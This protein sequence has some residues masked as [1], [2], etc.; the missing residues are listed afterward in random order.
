MGRRFGFKFK[1]IRMRTMVTILPCVLIAMAILVVMSYQSSKTIINEE[2]DKV[3]TNELEVSIAS[4]SIDLVA[5]R[6]VPIT[7]ARTVE[8]IGNELTEEEYVEL[9]T[10]FIKSNDGTLGTGV[11][12]EPNRYQPNRTYFGPYVYRDGDTIIFTSEY[13]DPSYDFHNEEWYLQGKSIQDGDAAVWSDPYFDDAGDEVLTF[14]STTA[15]FFDRHGNFMG[16]ATGDIELT[17]LLE[18]ISEITIGETGW[19]FMLGRDGTYIASRESEKIMNVNIKSDENESL[20]QL[21]EKM[22]AEGMGTSRF[23]NEDGWNRVYYKT[24]PETGWTMA[25]VIPEKELYAPLNEL[26]IK[27]LIITAMATGIVILVIFMFSRYFSAKVKSVTTLSQNMSEGDFTHRLD[28]DSVDEF[29]QMARNFNSMTSKLNDIFRHTLN[30]TESVAVSAKE[31]KEGAE[32]T[33]KAAEQISDATHELTDGIEIQSNVTKKAETVIHDITNRIN[34]ISS[35]VEVMTDSSV[36]ASHIAN[37]GEAVVKDTI[38]QMNTIQEKVNT[39]ADVVNTLGNKSKEIGQIVSY[40]TEISGQTN[41]LALN[42]AIEAA[43]AGEH[44]K[45]FAVV[46]DEVRKLAEQSSSAAEKI[47]AL[48]TEIQLEIDHSIQVMDEGTG[49]VKEGLD[50]VNN[51]GQSFNQITE[52]IKDVSSYTKEVNASI[53]QMLEQSRSMNESIESIVNVTKDS[54]DNIYNVVASVEEQI[55]SMEQIASTGDELYNMA[56]KLKLSISELKITKDNN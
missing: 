48:I 56:E 53:Q 46:A 43:R 41:L 55:A 6:Q 54:G 10:N 42:A 29:G 1:S 31:L 35:N 49:A 25:M 52:A 33:T 38:L 18:T 14:I 40:I 26:L 44:G 11:W 16:V 19:A 28:E 23:T 2:I 21:G 30:N 50:L 12:Y 51:A 32:Q 39:S 4:I 37:Q 17:T 13:E 8:S 15:P 36:S 34:H 22:L 3:M 47:S 45:G 9:L 20:Q 24:V 27:L 7:L 5:H